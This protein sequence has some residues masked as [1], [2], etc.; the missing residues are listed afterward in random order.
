MEQMDFDIEDMEDEEVE[1]QQP[2]F[3]QQRAGEEKENPDKKETVQQPISPMKKV[4]SALKEQ[5]MMI[6]QLL[7]YM[8]CQEKKI[9]KLL[10]Q[11]ESI[12]QKMELMQIGVSEKNKG[13]KSIFKV[14]EKKKKVEEKAELLKLLQQVDFGEDQLEQIQKGIDTGLS[15][16]EIKVYAVKQKSALQMEKIRE[17]YT[18]IKGEKNEQ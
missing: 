11:T 18:K 15:V 8:V 6:F 14:R 16:E 13:V 2:F 7:D 9:Q 12:I 4:D 3:A 5:K 1:V 17:M 10:E